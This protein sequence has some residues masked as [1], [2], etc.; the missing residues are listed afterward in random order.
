MN[1][2]VMKLV[3]AMS[4]ALA[5]TMP[6]AAMAQG[7]ESVELGAAPGAGLSYISLFM[8]RTLSSSW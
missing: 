1:C 8:E 6:L 4:T 7:V 2:K 5:S 3:V